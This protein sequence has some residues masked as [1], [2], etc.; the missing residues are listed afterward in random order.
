MRRAKQRYVTRFSMR[1]R[2][3]HFL[4]M[5]LFILL[6]LTGFPQKFFEAGWAQWVIAHLGGIDRVRWL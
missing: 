1:Q 6:A 5:V 3:E 4:I 2:V